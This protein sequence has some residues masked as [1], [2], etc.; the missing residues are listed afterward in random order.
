MSNHQKTPKEASKISTD[1]R[2]QRTRNAILSAANELMG[3]L[4]L[5]DVSTDEIILASKVSKQSFYNHFSD[6][7]S[8]TRELLKITRMELGKLVDRFNKDTTDPARRLSNALCIYAERAIS[9]PTQG[10]LVAM[11]SLQDTRLDSDS[12]SR[13]VTDLLAGLDTN[14]LSFMSVETGL[15]FVLGAGNGLISCILAQNQTETALATTQQFVTLVLRALGI[16]PLEAES[17]ASSSAE[18][19]IR[20]TVITICKT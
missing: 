20:P 8:V 15:A 19:I 13:V 18:E 1:P 3:D 5:E 12:N 16:S 10:K 6:K 2:R 9:N 7:K 11:L 17:I 4:G 14:R